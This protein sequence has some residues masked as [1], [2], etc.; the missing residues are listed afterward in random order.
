MSSI[1]DMHIK[2]RDGKLIKLSDFKGKV[3]L[4]VNVAPDS[5]FVEQLKGLQELYERFKDQGLVIMGVFSDDFGHRDDYDPRLQHPTDHYVVDF[6]LTEKVH[7]TDHED[8]Y[9]A[10]P[11]F[12]WINQEANDASITFGNVHSSFYKFLIGRR[13][14]F[15]DWFVPIT[16]PKSNRLI[17]AVQKALTEQLVINKGPT[18]SVILMWWVFLWV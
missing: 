14:Q 2:S 5:W 12:K 7:V 17:K 9:E 16:S 6:I 4:I 1:Y 18:T 15:I 3:L 11:L 8:H 10:H 13:G